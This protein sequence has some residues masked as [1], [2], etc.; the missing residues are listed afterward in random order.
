MQ[1][2]S[3]GV[4]LLLVCT[5]NNTG[6]LRVWALVRPQQYSI[7]LVSSEKRSVACPALHNIFPH[8]VINDTTFGKILLHTKRIFL[9]KFV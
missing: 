9:Y 5:V 2:L 6:T 7:T 8:Y 1:M 4:M 3:R